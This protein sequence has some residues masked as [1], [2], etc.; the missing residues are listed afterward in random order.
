MLDHKIAIIT[1]KWNSDFVN[2]CVDWCIWELKNKWMTLKQIDIIT[3]PGWVE[4]P[5][6]AKK[7]ANKWQY[8]AI[9][10]VGFICENPLYR[11]EFVAQSVID[12]I[13]KLS[14]EVN[15]PIL[16]SVLSPVNFHKDDQKQINF[17]RKHMKIKWIEVAESC[18]DII[19]IHKNIN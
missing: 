14:N 18:L 1:T 2:P 10:C 19:R 16:S 7:L 4:I 9:I 8:D 17:Y 11:Y 13:I 5:L 15:L 12:T 6:V 3:V